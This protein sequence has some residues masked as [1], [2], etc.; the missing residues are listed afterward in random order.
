V[1][2][3]ALRRLAALIV[4]GSAATAV[5]SLPVGLLLGSSPLRSM[6]V[7]FYLAGCFLMVIGFFAGN[8]GPARVKSEAPGPALLPFTF[9]GR[10]LRWAT[11]GEQHET[12][13]NSA[14]FVALGLILVV[15]GL[16]IDPNHTLF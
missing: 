13:N 8:R 1:L 14:I 9:S 6:T 3:A 16:L 10:R 12:I 2:L 11:Q 4:L 7:G 15:I 5:I